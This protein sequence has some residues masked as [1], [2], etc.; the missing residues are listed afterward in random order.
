MVPAP[1]NMARRGVMP[2]LVVAAVIA[3]V[4]GA[5]TAHDRSPT[6]GP[7]T[8]VGGGGE[9]PPLQALTFGSAPG[10]PAGHPLRSAKQ[11]ER[12]RSILV[13]E[14]AGKRIGKLEREPR[15]VRVGVARTGT[16]SL[17]FW[18]A[19]LAGTHAAERQPRWSQPGVLRCTASSYSTLA[20]GSADPRTHHRDRREE[21]GIKG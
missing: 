5:A 12:G 7:V 13:R 19:S 18:S 9:T 1:T 20:S 17:T 15:V 4:G 21:D 16:A 8:E 3:G 2:I 10:R 14:L 11:L 6:A